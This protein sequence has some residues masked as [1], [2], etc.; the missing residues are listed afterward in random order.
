M[1]FCTFILVFN[2]YSIYYMVFA[3]SCGNL[4]EG[5]I[6][7]LSIYT[8]I[9][10]P[11]DFLKDTNKRDSPCLCCN[12]LNGHAI[13]KVGIDLRTS[14]TALALLLVSRGWFPIIIMTLVLHVTV[15]KPLS[16][17]SLSG[18]LHPEGANRMLKFDIIYVCTTILVYTL[19]NNVSSV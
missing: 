8:S 3:I 15:L 11:V 4:S 19:V 9:Y 2:S 17:S 18:G 5:L 1:Y 14:E 16:I 13:G 12:Y 6:Q 7:F 10:I